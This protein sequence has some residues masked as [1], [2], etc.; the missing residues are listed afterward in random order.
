MK[1]VFSIPEELT[2]G[3]FYHKITAWFLQLRRTRSIAWGNIYVALISIII[4][5]LLVTQFR[6]QANVIKQ[7]RAQSEEDLGQ[8]IRDLN[9]ETDSLQQQA[10]ELTVQLYRYSQ[11]EEDKKAI[12]AQAAKNLQNLETSSGLTSVSG[13][14]IIF[15]IKDKEGFLNNY[16]LLD[17]IQELRAAGAEAIS[18]NDNRI[19][20]STSFAEN[21]KNVIIDDTPIKPPYEIKAIGN[22]EVLEQAITILGGIKDTFSSFEGISLEI[23]QTQVTVLPV[24]K[25]IKFE[26]AKP[27]KSTS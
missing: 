9:Q 13:Q 14:G 16:D 19:V 17:T 21:R 7:L 25:K 27:L 20:A 12:L 6:S 18:I 3:N 10:T 24:K 26:V 8:I 2:I 15:L 4:G 1:K 22:P 11:T 23:E 5:I